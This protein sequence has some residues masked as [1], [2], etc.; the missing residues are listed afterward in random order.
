MAPAPAPPPTNEVNE[1]VATGSRRE[2][3]PGGAQ[4]ASRA[5][6]AEKASADTDNRIAKLLAAALAGRTGEVRSLLAAGVPVDAPDEAGETA[7]MKSIEGKHPVVAELLR[8]H[9]A[10]L[11]LRN[12]AG[13]SARDMAAAVGDPQL[14][15][16]L[17][18]DR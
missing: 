15:K 16:A 14:D 8:R 17:D 6:A 5:M 13:V 7:L 3:P 9:G 1:M 12:H 10:D 18:L 11:D 2:A 4:R